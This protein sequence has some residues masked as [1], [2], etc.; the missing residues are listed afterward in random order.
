MDIDIFQKSGQ[1]LNLLNI[2]EYC[3]VKWIT[4]EF[5]SKSNKY[6][7]FVGQINDHLIYHNQF[8]TNKKTQG[9]LPNSAFYITEFYFA[10]Q[11]WTNFFD[12]T[13]KP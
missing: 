11:S 7:Y 5:L 2:S 3:Q 4:T 13:Y 9:G 10:E 6:L 12:N 8:W 1:F